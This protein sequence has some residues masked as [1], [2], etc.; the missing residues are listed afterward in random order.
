VVWGGIDAV[1]ADVLLVGHYLGVVPQTAE[2]KLDEL[3]SGT[4]GRDGR[5][6]LIT[7]LTK[8]GAI[9][10]DLSQILLFPTPD[11][12]QVAL[13]GMGP[14][15]T[16]GSAQ[17]RVLA[18]AVAQ[19]IG[20]LPTHRA[21]AMVLIGSGK[22]NL[23]VKD[24][25]QAFLEGLAEAFSTE[26]LGLDVL[27]IVERDLDRA[28]EIL[29]VVKES[30]AHLTVQRANRSGLEFL[31]HPEL[32][33][34]KGGDISPDFGCSMM[35]AA[36]AAGNGRSGLPQMS[37]A[38]RDVLSHLPQKLHKN[39]LERLAAS[40]RD[41]PGRARPLRDIAMQFR[42]REPDRPHDSKDIPSRLAFWRIDNDVCA[43]AITNTTTVTE[44][45][46]RDRAPLIEQACDRLHN[47][48]PA[49]LKQRTA[50]LYRLLI[51]QE[52]KEILKRSDPIV[53]EVDRWL[54]RVQW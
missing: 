5:T 42:L 15:G 38:L 28:L 3:V 13:G 8:R 21:L 43:A 27:E 1:Q 54:A 47:P 35:L 19:V 40:N 20:L 44:R 45:A 23:K 32:I 50:T 31:P 16:F 30:A 6:L 46:I 36:L 10:G 48:D 26:L 17:V 7:E 25:L 41:G 24:A 9:R 2:R 18:R 33:E 51:P 11:G 22:G 37:R 4:D 29:A 49:R 53:I 12:R 14:V 52:L 39:L 34:G